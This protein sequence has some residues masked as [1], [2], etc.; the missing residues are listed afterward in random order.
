[1]KHQTNE[2]GNTPP[3]QAKGKLDETKAKR[4]L[5]KTQVNQTDG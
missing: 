4:D 5:K 2:I 1:M 3:P